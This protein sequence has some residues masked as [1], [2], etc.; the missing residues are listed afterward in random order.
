MRCNIKLVLA[1]PALLALN[2]LFTT[3][4]AADQ[5]NYTAQYECRAGSAICNVDVAAL[6][7]QSCQQTITPSDSAGT[8]S[9]KVNSGSQYI[10]IT[11]GDYTG[12]G[13]IT[14]TASGSAGAYKILRYYRSGDNNDEPWNQGGNQVKLHSIVVDR[15]DFW[16]LHRLTFPSLDV[17]DRIFFQYGASDSIVSRILV[18]G[19]GNNI[20]R[21]VY[22]AVGSWGNFCSSVDRIT[23]QNSVIRNQPGLAD[24]EPIGIAFECGQDLHIVNNE[25]YDWS[26]HAIQ[27]GHNGGP[28]MPGMVVE[29]NDLYISPA[30]YTN[31]GTSSTAESPFVFK[32]YGSAAKPAKLLHNRI[33]GARWPD[34]SQCCLGGTSGDAVNI[35]VP[36]GV[37]A[38][39]ILIQNNIIFDNQ[40][41]ITWSNGAHTRQSVIGN[42]FY[43]HRRYSSRWNS[44]AL[45]AWKPADSQIYLNTIVDA[46]MYA[47]SFANGLNSTDIRC[48][49]ILAS[50]PREPSNT[51]DG[52]T[53]MDANAFYG[54]PVSTVNGAVENVV[55]SLRV[56]AANTAYNVGEII[57]VGSGAD[58]CTVASDANC[59][60]YKVIAPGTTGGSQPQFCTQLGCTM[61][62]GSVAMQAVR[63]PY[64]FY[65]KLKTA[66]ERMVIPFARVYTGAPEAYA[67]PADYDAR[68]SIGIS[69]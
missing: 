30:I 24:I 66:P 47:I 20:Y 1:L 34:T 52:T 63:G 59:F 40:V 23:I 32:G 5:N 13:P 37:T 27:L 14:I 22:S 16:I 38:S 69:G 4:S 49:A 31:N 51:P 8:I 11:P 19:R 17:S 18:E 61:T 36:D 28:Q 25:I 12:K 26:S 10:C 55:A 58:D 60:L 15:A 29:N 62:D 65:R 7:T 67:C 46:S 44:H 45:E 48:N 33:W 9:A 41:G 50:G 21:N 42:I 68:R 57:R 64:T 35:S 2:T 56:H 54:S 39:Y 53:R 3:A 6:T 43:K